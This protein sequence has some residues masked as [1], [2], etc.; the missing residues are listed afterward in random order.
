M[1]KLKVLK[2]FRDKK[3]HKTWYKP[4]QTV[5]ISD[6]ERINDLVTRGLCAVAG[7]KETG[8]KSGKETGKKSG[9]QDNAQQ[10]SN[11]PADQNAT[12]EE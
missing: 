4:G 11:D 7:G 3:D 8:K 12:G 9:K 5:N 10:P 1:A 6:E 2:P